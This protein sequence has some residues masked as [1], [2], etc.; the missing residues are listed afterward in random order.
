[1]CDIK[2][3][4]TQIERVEN[5]VDT[6]T[7]I[8][9]IAFTKTWNYVNSTEKKPIKLLIFK[10]TVMDHKYKALLQNIPTR[11]VITAIAKPADRP[12]QIAKLRNLDINNFFILGSL[13]SIRDVLGKQRVWITHRPKVKLNTD[14]NLLHRFGERR[15][16]STQF[17]M[18]RNHTVRPNFYWPF[19]SIFDS[20]SAECAFVS[21]FR[22]SG[23]VSCNCKNATIIF[24]KPVPD[25]S[26][27]DRLGLMVG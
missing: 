27:K 12:Q 1:M 24:L 7:Q 11:H 3:W 13:Q 16:F 4:A 5:W 18:A 26:A 20:M 25:Q 6:N 8:Q 17:R 23:E 19:S 10:S 22:Y 14:L 15:V 9:T 21:N 2:Y